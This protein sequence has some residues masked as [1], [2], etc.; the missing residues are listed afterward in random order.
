[1]NNTKLANSWKEPNEVPNLVAIPA[2]IAVN[3]SIPTC[4]ERIKAAPKAIKV[5]PINDII[6]RKKKSSG[7]LITFF[8]LS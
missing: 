1:M 4:P 2:F 5:T 6:A 8:E 7:L 3:G